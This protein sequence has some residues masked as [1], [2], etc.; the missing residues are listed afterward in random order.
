MS[1][2]LVMRF[3]FEIC[4]SNPHREDETWTLDIHVCPSELLF[5]VRQIVFPR[6][7]QLPTSCYPSPFSYSIKADRRHYSRVVLGRLTLDEVKKVER[8]LFPSPDEVV[9]MELHLGWPFWA[10]IPRH[11]KLVWQAGD[12]RQVMVPRGE[13]HRPRFIPVASSHR[14]D[15]HR[16]VA[17]TVTAVQWTIARTWL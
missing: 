3:L 15:K 11:A 9:W 16:T 5:K 13:Y 6:V 2:E 12:A 4:N 1:K 17:V 7:L 14:W 8:L 10:E